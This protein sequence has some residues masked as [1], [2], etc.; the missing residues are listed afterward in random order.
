MTPYD[1]L[2]TLWLKI[3]YARKDFSSRRKWRDRPEIGD[4]VEDCR[5]KVLRVKAF[6]TT[7]DDL[8]L[9]DGSTASWMHCCDYP[10]RTDDYDL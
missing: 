3:R 1:W 7:E 6:G 8:I 2:W 9:E 10:E 5:G 4:L